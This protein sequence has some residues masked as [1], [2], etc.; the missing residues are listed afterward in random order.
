MKIVTMNLFLK[1]T[2]SFLHDCRNVYDLTNTN[3]WLF[4][5]TFM[6]GCM[7]TTIVCENKSQATRKFCAYNMQHAAQST[8]TTGASHTK[9]KMFG[10]FTRTK[11]VSF[12]W[13]HPSESPLLYKQH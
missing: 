5:R 6:L 10:N 12:L 4:D 3:L 8:I 9:D 1:G 2:K 7:L 13:P 11:V